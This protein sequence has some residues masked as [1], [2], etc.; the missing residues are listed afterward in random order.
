MRFRISGP[1][2]GPF[3]TGFSFRPFGSPRRGT[4]RRPA[5]PTGN[6]VYVVR[7][8]SNL[9]KVGISTNPEARLA[10][11]QTGTGFR[12][13]LAYVASCDNAAAVERRT[14]DLL[15][16]HRCQ[17]EW[18]DCE[19]DVAVAAIH[20]ASYQL[21]ATTQEGFDP[22]ARSSDRRFVIKPARAAAVLVLFFV[23]GIALKASSE[24]ISRRKLAEM[25]AFVRL[26]DKQCANAGGATSV[27][28][29]FAASDPSLDEKEIA[30]REQYLITLRSKIGSPKWCALYETEMRAAD[31]IVAASPR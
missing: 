17:G 19:A 27:F 29:L 3:R 12:L 9:V 20:A 26:F 22:T 2:L 6:F 24:N 31:A 21:G 11:L 5:G 7:G 10:N 25:V 13:A 1:R 15:A 23:S 4:P 18:F 14:H 30:E 16:R 28:K 8:D